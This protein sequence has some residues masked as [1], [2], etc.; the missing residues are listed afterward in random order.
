[1]HQ[2]NNK[3]YNSAGLL[4]N[5][6]T[7]EVTNQSQKL[8]L[9]PVN[10]RVLVVL[11]QAAKD[12]VSRQQL[13]DAVWPNQVISDDALT[14]S[15]SDLRSQLKQL[16]AVEPLIE[17]IPKVGYR[18]KSVVDSER[19]SVVQAKPTKATFWTTN[20]KPMLVA[21]VILFLLLW[22][23]LGWIYKA[24]QSNTTPLIILPTAY[25]QDGQQAIETNKAN[26]ADWLKQ[27]VMQ[28]HQMQYLSSYALESYDEKPFPFYSHEFGVRWF[29]ESQITHTTDQKTLNL[30]LIDAKTAMV[31]Y[32]QQHHFKQT[33]ELKS[34][35]NE[36]MAFVA[37]L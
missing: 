16:T 36:F 15:I 20:L 37:T 29:I 23:L 35:C 24:A 31:V 14:R 33:Q 9:S 34:H 12:T 10:S 7:G 17:T 26:V 2:D 28:H 4:I 25:I 19:Q 8:R 11:L 18:W 3:Y 32:S 22:G 5:V 13:F 6:N 21:L 1:M 30:N 27:A